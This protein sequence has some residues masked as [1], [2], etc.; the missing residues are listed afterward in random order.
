[1]SIPGGLELE[2][3]PLNDE[4]A[5]IITTP[6]DKIPE[7]KMF[8]PVPLAARLTTGVPNVKK[9]VLRQRELIK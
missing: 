6:V 3:P 9:L 5:D 7:T 2:V 1:M 8:V 4:Q